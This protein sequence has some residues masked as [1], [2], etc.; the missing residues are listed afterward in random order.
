[1]V[2]VIIENKAFLNYN[3]IISKYMFLKGRLIW[4]KANLNRMIMMYLMITP[5]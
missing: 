5:M 3:N 2:F 4:G 1:M